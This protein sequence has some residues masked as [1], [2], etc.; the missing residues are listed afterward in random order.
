MDYPSSTTIADNDWLFGALRI[1]ARLISRESGVSHAFSSLSLAFGE[2][3]SEVLTLDLKHVV[4]EKIVQAK[5]EITNGTEDYGRWRATRGNPDYSVYIEAR[6]GYSEEIRKLGESEK[7]LTVLLEV[8]E[9]YVGGFGSVEL[10]VEACQRYRE[11]LNLIRQES[12]PDAIYVA[13]KLDAEDISLCMAWDGHH[14]R[15]ESMLNAVKLAEQNLSSYN[16]CRLLSAR[17]AERSAKAYYTSLGYSVE[18]VS[19]LQL[20]GKDARWKDF[21]LLAGEIA[22]DVK[23]ARSSF[24]TPDAYVEHCVPRFKLNRDTQ[25]DVSIV[26]VF[27]PYASDLESILAGVAKCQILGQ[28]NVTEIRQLYRWMRGRFGAMLNLDGLW[29]HGFLPGWIFDYPIEQYKD[30]ES[31]RSAVSQLLDIFEKVQ[32]RLRKD[33][34]TWMLGLVPGHPI[35]GRLKLDD[36]Y[37]QVLNDLVDLDNTVGIKRSSVYVYSMGL[38]LEAILS[39][40]DSMATFEA[41]ERIIFVDGESQSPLGLIDTK[42]YVR[43][44]VRMLADVQAE[45]QK[46][47]LRFQAFR[48]PH[49][50]IL[51]GLL[52]DGK[53]KSLIAYCGGWLERPFK[54]KCG[55][56]PLFFGKHDTC[57]EC[58]RLVCDACGFC[59]ETCS[60][61]QRRKAR[62]GNSREE[63]PDYFLDDEDY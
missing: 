19:L 14:V 41:L 56:S 36:Q 53:W 63:H 54:V 42:K 7:Q 50:A 2:R 40:H 32:P 4:Q 16:A 39:K 13:A 5:R 29:N 33:I 20:E 25:N 28:V 44:L 11:T 57:P 47:N 15:P 22:L 46:Q 43:N 17:A 12:T 18:D 26:G 31:I 45:A 1:W 34:P 58:G 48:M 35:I 61:S 38:L 10:L 59:S 30:R 62:L 60:L 52:F 23:N 21:D 24:T 6:D 51:K 55:A 37:N 3:I 8:L 49:P 9:Q 27:S